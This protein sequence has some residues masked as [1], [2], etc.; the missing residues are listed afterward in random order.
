MTDRFDRALD[1]IQ[2]LPKQ[3]RPPALVIFGVAVLLPDGFLVLDY[4]QDIQDR[5]AQEVLQAEQKKDAGTIERQRQWIDS[6]LKKIP[7]ATSESCDCVSN[8]INQDG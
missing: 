6:L 7:N 8:V 4:I 2:R 3:F 1:I 5:S